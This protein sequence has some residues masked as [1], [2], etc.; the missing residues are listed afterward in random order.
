MSPLPTTD[1]E[2]CPRCPQKSFGGVQWPK[3]TLFAGQKL[4]KKVINTKTKCPQKSF[5]GVQWPKLHLFCESKTAK[6]KKK[7]NPKCF[8]PNAPKVT[9]G[10]QWP[11]VAFFLWAKYAPKL[12]TNKPRTAFRKRLCCKNVL[13]RFLMTF[14]GIL[15]I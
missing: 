4:P 15:S 6:K 11:K 1:P 13:I 7:K 12:K 3:F 14:L 2:C 10:V 5:G 8:V 9:W